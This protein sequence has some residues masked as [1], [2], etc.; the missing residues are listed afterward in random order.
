MLSRRTLLLSAAAT[1]AAAL[2]STPAM[3]AEPMIFAIGGIAIRGA[4]TVA[5]FTQGAL[6]EGSSN[7]AVIWDG[8][9]WYFASL[10][11]MEMFLANPTAYAPQYGGY[12]AFTLSRGALATSV[13]EAWTVYDNKLYLNHSLVVRQT[14]MEDVPG[15]IALADAQ[16]P[17]ILG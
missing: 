1:P 2:F 5:F 11:N 16:W 15:N 12:C 10:A 8:A 7:Y 4:D 14:W 6:V 13:S 9:T 17:T 3:A